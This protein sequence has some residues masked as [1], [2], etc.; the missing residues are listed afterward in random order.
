VAG[1]QP[2]EIPG[3]PRSAGARHE[4]DLSLS[5]DGHLPLSTHGV[6]VGDEVSLDVSFA[7][8]QARLASLIRGGLLGAASAQAY[9]D[10]I[11]GLAPPGPPGPAPGLSRL[12][13]VYFRDLTAH[14]HSVSMA[15][16]W[17]VTGPSGGLFPVLD[18]DITLTLSGQRS[19]TLTL[20]GAYRPPPGAALDQAVVHQAATA[21]MQAFLDRIAQ[22]IA[23]PATA[24]GP[25]AAAAGPD[26]PALPSEP[27][28]K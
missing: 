19:T 3:R 4:G 2:P 17:E 24:A 11:T 26:P 25:Q 18:A 23:H 5:P 7:A 14:G 6:F 1:P 28:T 21:T 10:G 27:D 22:A 9:R 13:Q 16:R 15:L 20:T 12:V 8:A